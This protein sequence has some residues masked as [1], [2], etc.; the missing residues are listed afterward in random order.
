MA[1]Q[2]LFRL[3]NPPTTT[4]AGFRS[5][6]AF[7][8]GGASSPATVATTPEPRP[9]PPPN[10]PAGFVTGPRGG[11]PASAFGHKR[12]L[13]DFWKR[14]AVE[15]ISDQPEPV[16]E[17][18]KQLAPIAPLGPSPLVPL[19]ANTADGNAIAIRVPSMAEAIEKKI[20]EDDEEAI[21]A[22][23]LASIH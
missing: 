15:E 10:N 3:G 17:P 20:L 8:I 4:Q 22:I 21:V 7:W 23:L 9:E 12:N 14:P 18:E 6:L 5:L 1:F 11:I 16:I 19:M 2:P 13:E